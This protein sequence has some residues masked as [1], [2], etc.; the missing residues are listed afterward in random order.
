MF[1][2]EMLPA[3]RGDCLW[4]EYGKARKPNRVLIDGGPLVS[5]KHLRDRIEAL[6]SSQRRFDLL[7]I[8]HVD[9]DHIEGIVKLLNDPRIDV[10][11]D[12]VWFN[13]YKQLEEATLA[14]DGMGGMEGEYLSA[15]IS[16]RGLKHNKAFGGRPVM[17]PPRANSSLPAITLEGGLKLTLLSP[18]AIQLKELRPVWKKT[19][20]GHGIR[21]GDTSAA[22]RQLASVRRFKPDD[23][24]GP[25]HSTDVDRLQNS[26][27]KADDSEANASS[28]AFLA[29]FEGRSA[30]LTGDAHSKVVEESLKKVMGTARKLKTGA[31]KLSHHGSKHNTSPNLIR[32]L[33]CPRFLFSSNGARFYHPHSEAVAWAIRNGGVEPILCF[34]YVSDDNRMWLETALKRKHKYKTESPT[35]G[36]GLL[37][38]L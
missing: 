7:V 34:N 3:E 22:L 14:A 19:V 12:D 32:L 27:F 25:A 2:I 30:V 1:R 11:F 33:D 13:G 20:E 23:S 6:P 5:F 36:D 28:I 15:L 35:S 38:D 8:T 18:G 26:T 10:R 9:I 37:I 4:I 24:M 17:I 21:G 16:S 29:E 31:L